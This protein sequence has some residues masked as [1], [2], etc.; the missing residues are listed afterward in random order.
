MLV[1]TCFSLAWVFVHRG[2]SGVLALDPVWD[3]RGRRIF[4]ALVIVATAALAIDF[5]RQRERLPAR[6]RQRMRAALV[7]CVIPLPLALWV[8][9]AEPMWGRWQDGAAEDKLHFVS[10][11][12]LRV[13]GVSS[14]LLAAW[15]FVA[16]DM[17][18]RGTLAPRELGQA[19]FRALASNFREWFPLLLLLPAYSSMAGVIGQPARDFDGAMQVFDA[20]LWGGTQPVVALQRIISTAL[21]EWC[22]FSYAFY[23]VQ[24]PLSLAAVL[25]LGGR[26]ALREAVT[27][28]SLGLAVTYISY[29]LIPVK[30]P[31][32]SL[33]FE[34]PLD[35]Y[36]VAEVKEMLMDRGRITWDCFPSFHTAGS[37]LMLWACFRHARGVF[38]ASLPM[39]LTIPFACVYL[40]YHYVADVLAGI[41]LFALVAWVTPRLLRGDRAAAEVVASPTR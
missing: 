3:V 9:A 8:V 23:A 4:I 26:L 17:R 34:V 1:F 21:S 25:A 7:L 15:L 11:A 30:G 40:R 18:R 37:L 24:Y 16:R 10:M 31:A 12:V 32:L 27:G 14:P 36:F 29:V 28:L 19:A 13:A 41:A 33:S 39:V 20:W 2:W 35:L 38:W 6:W 22:A 5:L